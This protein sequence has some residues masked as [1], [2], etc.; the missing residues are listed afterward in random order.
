MDNA[1]LEI[2]YVA[3]TIRTHRGLFVE[4]ISSSKYSRNCHCWS[5]YLTK[6]QDKRVQ[7]RVYSPQSRVYSPQN[8]IKL[9]QRCFFRVF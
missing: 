3:A 2:W 8:S 1:I 6:T 9:H 4:I 5:Y 7:T